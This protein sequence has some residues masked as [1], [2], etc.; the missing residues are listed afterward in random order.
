MP[1][2]VAEKVD[3]RLLTGPCAVFCF[4]RRTDW[5]PLRAC[6][7]LLREAAPAPARGGTGNFQ[8]S[9]SVYIDKKTANILFIP[10]ASGFF[11][12]IPIPLLS[13]DGRLRYFFMPC[14]AAGGSGGRH[15]VQSGMRGSGSVRNG[16]IRNGTDGVIFAV[17]PVN[18]AFSGSVQQVLN[19]IR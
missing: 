16:K 10:Q 12:Q 7:V 6:G 1:R 14:K 13:F 5:L 19:F 2:R 15:A 17:F 11:K 9:V 18:G 4:H 8:F 3:Y